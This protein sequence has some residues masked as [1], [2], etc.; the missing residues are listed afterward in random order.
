M[1]HASFTVLRDPSRRKRTSRAR[2]ITAPD[3]Q[4]RTL[5]RVTGSRRCSRPLRMAPRREAVN[6][7]DCLS[8]W[9]AS[10]LECQGRLSPS[11]ATSASVLTGLAALCVKDACPSWV[12][13]CRKDY[14]RGITARLVT[15]ML[16]IRRTKTALAARKSHS[17]N[18]G[19]RQVELRADVSI[20]ETNGCSRPTRAVDC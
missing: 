3:T 19:K 14:R 15:R 12:A 9:P 2:A 4:T 7:A 1:G 17:A 16:V 6:T 18:V 20:A 13:N 8:S 5:A 10:L 11:P